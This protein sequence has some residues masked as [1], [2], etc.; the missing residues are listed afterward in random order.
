MFKNSSLSFLFICLVCA[1]NVVGQCLANAGLDI[2]I[3]D[4]DG[5]SSNWVYLD[6]TASTVDSGEVKYE[7]TVLNEV[8]DGSWRETL[9]IRSSDPTSLIQGLNTP[10]S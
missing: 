5:T 10:K 6:G 1:N 7:W 9:V 8:G 3:C 2:A 4:G